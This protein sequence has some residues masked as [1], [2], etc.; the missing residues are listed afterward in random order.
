MLERISI[1][2][3]SR[4]GESLADGV[5]EVFP[6]NRPEEEA[7]AQPVERTGGIERHVIQESGLGS[8]EDIRDP[9]VTLNRRSQLPLDSFAADFYQVLKFIDNQCDGTID[10]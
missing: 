6:R 9:G 7:S 2:G 3:E 1:D 8:S 10:V 5:A 4:S